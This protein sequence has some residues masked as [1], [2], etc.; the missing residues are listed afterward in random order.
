MRVLP[1]PQALER[2]LEWCSIRPTHL[3]DAN[4]QGFVIARTHHN[5]AIARA[6]GRFHEAKRVDTHN[7]ERWDGQRG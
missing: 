3:E 7:V 2:G 4:A 5:Q 1:S 6:L